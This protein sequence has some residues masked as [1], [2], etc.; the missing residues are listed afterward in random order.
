MLNT[1][2]RAAILRLRREGHGLRTI[3]RALGISRNAVRR[4]LDSGT[5]QVPPMARARYGG[6]AFTVR[7]RRNG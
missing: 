2:T 6:H 7:R 4:V 5:E 1:D 3:A